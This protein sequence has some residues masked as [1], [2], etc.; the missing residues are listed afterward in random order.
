ML[1]Q[2]NLVDAPNGP[3]SV[4]VTGPG[5]FDANDVSGYDDRAIVVGLDGLYRYVRD[6]NSVDAGEDLLLSPDG[7][8]VAG[9]ADLEGVDWGES[10]LDWQSTAGVMDLTTGEV[11]TYHEGPPVAWSPGGRLLTRASTGELKLLDVGSGEAV[12]LGVPGAV[13]VAFSPDGRQLALQLGRELKVLNVG[14]RALR[15]VADLGARQLLAAP[16]AWTVGGRLAIWDGTDCLPACPAGYTDFRLSFVDINGGAVTDAALDPVQSVS[17]RLLGWQ[18]D[19]GAVV[20]LGMTSH[21]PAG[22]HLGAP[23]VLALHRG[24]GRTTLITVAADADRIDIARTLLDQFGG[25]SRSGWDMFLDIVRLRLRQATPWLAVIAVLIAA[26]LTYRRIRDGVWSSLPR[27][28]RNAAPLG[29][30]RPNDRLVSH[31]A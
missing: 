8:Y 6:I 12:P 18:D 20:V 22:P 15:A 21:D 28:V 29:D 30:Q 2:P 19:G 13:A 9:R 14:T 11:R 27:R 7:R 4:I 5:G 25:E 23:Q 17:A 1:L 16:G 26:P 24:R 3:A 31:D 10:A